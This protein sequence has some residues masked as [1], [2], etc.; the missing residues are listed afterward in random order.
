[1]LLTYRFQLDSLADISLVVRGIYAAAAAINMCSSLA[2]PCVMLEAY[3]NCWT[4][5]CRFA[6]VLAVTFGPVWFKVL[7]QFN[8]ELLISYK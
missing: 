8:V 7:E 2:L 3:D 1:M 5:F 4:I 6:N